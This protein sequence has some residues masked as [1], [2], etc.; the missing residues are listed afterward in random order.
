[1]ELA[2]LGQIPI[3]ETADP[4]GTAVLFSIVFWI[5]FMI[6]RQVV[7]SSR[8]SRF[9]PMPSPARV[10]QEGGVDV[11]TG[12]ARSKI[13]ALHV[14]IILGFDGL[15]LY[16]AGISIGTV[17]ISFVVLVSLYVLPVYQETCVRVGL[18]RDS[19]P[20]SPHFG[21]VED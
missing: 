3:P 13:N 12:I 17:Y 18:M 11:L 15:V 20:L 19:W 14:A 7:W 8:P 9:D 2:I 10:L 16:S 5:P 6:R 4:V 21:L 1:M